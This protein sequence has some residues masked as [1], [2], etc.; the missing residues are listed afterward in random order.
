[1]IVLRAHS[2]DKDR[3]TVEIIP[4]EALLAKRI[5]VIYE[6]CMLYCHPTSTGELRISGNELRKILI[7]KILSGYNTWEQANAKQ[8]KV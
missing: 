7:E 4:P 5:Q 1:M 2:T 3:N 6:H 8:S